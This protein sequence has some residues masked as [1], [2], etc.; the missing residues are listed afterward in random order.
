MNFDDKAPNGVSL[1][2]LSSIITDE[3]IQTK[4]S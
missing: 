1:H 3:V 4:Q 2:P